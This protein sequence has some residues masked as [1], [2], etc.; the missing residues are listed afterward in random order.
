MK[1]LSIQS[2]SQRGLFA[3][4]LSLVFAV[5]ASATEDNPG[6][7]LVVATTDSL[8]S[9]N[10]RWR[11]WVDAQARYFDFGSGAAQ[12]LVHPAIGY[13]LNS[14]A[15]AWFGYARFRT[16]SRSGFYFDE[17]RF[18][19]QLSWTGRPVG[20]G[21]LSLRA[22]LEQRAVSRGDD[23][24]ITL[25][26]MGKYVQPIGKSGRTDLVLA[27]EPFFSLVDTDWGGRARLS[28]NRVFLGFGQRLSDS[29]RLEAGYMNQYF[30]NDNADDIDNHLA[31][32]NFRVAF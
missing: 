3:V 10:S 22:R 23:V 13:E 31:V 11:Y 32:L 6:A 8:G 30:W 7:W 1:K 14:N 15:T 9:D 5:P 20:P 21:R 27:A 24:G 18:W 2:A 28:Q 12:Y 16:R 19:Q 17:D 29:V 26:L 4:I 25:R